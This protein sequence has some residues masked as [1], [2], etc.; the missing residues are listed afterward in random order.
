MGYSKKYYPSLSLIIQEATNATEIVRC[1]QQ[2][3]TIIYV[4]GGSIRETIKPGESRIS[5]I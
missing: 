1:S 2:G 4:L 5:S 3:K